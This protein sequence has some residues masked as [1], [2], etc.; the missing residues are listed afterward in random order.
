MEIITKRDAT[1][2]NSTT[3]MASVRFAKLQFMFLLGPQGGM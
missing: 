3:P 1:T 2:N